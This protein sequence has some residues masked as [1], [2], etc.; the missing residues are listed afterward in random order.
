M[1]PVCLVENAFLEQGVGKPHQDAALHLALDLQ[2]IDRP[3]AILDRDHALDP[4]DAR[5]GIDGDLG[6]LDAA[7][8]LLCQRGIPHPAAKPAVIIAARSDGADAIRAQQRAA[9]PKLMPRRG[10]SRTRMRPSRA[11]R[12][13]G[14]VRSGR[15]PLRGKAIAER[16]RRR[17]GPA[18]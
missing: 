10:S 6:K 11:I 4:H 15:A 7:Q 14:G 13:V 17:C 12:S 16:A 2:R 1:R 3:A 8:I 5:L 9:S 18:A